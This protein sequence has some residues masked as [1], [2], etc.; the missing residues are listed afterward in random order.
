MNPVHDEP[1]SL[2]RRSRRGSTSARGGRGTCG[3][4]GIRRRFWRA[5]IG[6]ARNVEGALP[7]RT[8]AR[9]R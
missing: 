1:C 3:G 9:R 4:T 2:S 6:P 8:M 7:L 5:P